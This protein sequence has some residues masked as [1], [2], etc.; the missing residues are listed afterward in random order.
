[1]HARDRIHH[2]TNEKLKLEKLGNKIL[3]NVNFNEKYS[4]FY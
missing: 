3:K 2:F 4:F 1:M